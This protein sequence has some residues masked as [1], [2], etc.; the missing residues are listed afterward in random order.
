MQKFA[1]LLIINYS[2]SN[3]GLVVTKPIDEFIC[4]CPVNFIWKQ[5]DW[6]IKTAI[7]GYLMYGA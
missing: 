2:V 6:R 5:S 1:V 7:A 4:G 3:T